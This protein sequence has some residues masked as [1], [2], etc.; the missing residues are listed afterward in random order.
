MHPMS[1]ALMRSYFDILSEERQ[2]VYTHEGL[3]MADLEAQLQRDAELDYQHR[4]PLLSRL[5][6]RLHLRAAER[7]AEPS[8]T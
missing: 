5:K 7:T 6:G 1:P 8:A 4:G 3:V 2:K